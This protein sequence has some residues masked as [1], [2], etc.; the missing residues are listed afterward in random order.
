MIAA[1]KLLADAGF[2]LAY[3]HLERLF[4]REGIHS[5]ELQAVFAA[6]VIEETTAALE[7]LS[8][9]RARSLH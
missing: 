1:K 9:P 5:E 3:T 4:V 7:H 6:A 8:R 2:S